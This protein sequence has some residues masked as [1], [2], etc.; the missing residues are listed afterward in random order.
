MYVCIYNIFRPYFCHTCL[1]GKIYIYYPIK[2]VII[3]PKVG[4]MKNKVK[5]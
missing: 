4:L 1:G 5:S 2:L 3:V